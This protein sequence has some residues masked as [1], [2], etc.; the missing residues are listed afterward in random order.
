MS[1]LE[2]F[3]VGATGHRGGRRTWRPPRPWDTDRAARD[4]VYTPSS[5][6]AE[7]DAYLREYADRSAQ[8][9]KLLPWRAIRYGPDDAEMLHFFPATQPRATQPRMTQPRATQPR[10]TQHRAPLHVFIHGGYWQELSEAESSFAASDF[11]SRGSAFAALGYGLAPRHRL[12]EIVTMVRKGVRWLHRH[13]TA[14]GV[15]SGRIFLS[16]SSAGA[17]LAAMCLLEGWLPEPLRP[18]DVVR[19]ATLLSGVYEL[20]PLG[21]TYIGEAIGLGV[22]EASRNSPI[23]HLPAGL[24]PLIVARGGVETEAFVDQHD[25]LVNALHQLGAPVIDLIVPGR[26]HFDL[27]LGLG[28]P[29]DALG[30]AVLA[31]MELTAVPER[32]CG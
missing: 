14:L 13:A 11:V 30:S 24:P 15:D 1:V 16:G 6:V 32:E 4:R 18:R 29:A 17:Q 21:H 3:P 9:R 27:P 22:G 8:A 12:D 26:N 5:C 10:M 31:Q 19:G 23:R 28:D 20:E 7:M 25:D 2:R